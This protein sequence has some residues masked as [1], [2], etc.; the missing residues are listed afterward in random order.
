MIKW[1]NK[2]LGY[3]YITYVYKGN[4]YDVAYVYCALTKNI[5]SNF[6]LLPEKYFKDSVTLWG[7]KP[8]EIL[9]HKELPNKLYNKHLLINK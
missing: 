2:L 8:N 5:D 7:N 9:Y 1:F 6:N 4:C 3:K